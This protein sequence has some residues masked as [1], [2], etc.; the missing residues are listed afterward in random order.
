[1]TTAEM[2]GWIFYRQSGGGD[3]SSDSTLAHFG[4]NRSLSSVSF[5]SSPMISVSSSCSMKHNL[6]VQ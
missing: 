3:P 2:T 6:H 1:M 4:G 5:S